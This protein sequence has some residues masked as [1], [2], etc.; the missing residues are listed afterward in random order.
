MIPA[1]AYTPGSLVRW[2]VQAAGPSGEVRDP[3]L[4]SEGPKYYG[5]IVADPSDPAATLPV[6][7]L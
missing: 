4:D 1:S 6:V 5:T 3:V 2:A 7:E